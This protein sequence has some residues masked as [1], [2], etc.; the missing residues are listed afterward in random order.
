MGGLTAQFELPTDPS[1]IA[2]ARRAVSNIL[3][4]WGFTDPDWLQTAGLLV[5][6]LVSNAI[7]HG[8]GCLAVDLSLHEGAVTVGAADGNSVVPYPR[9]AEG[10]GGRGLLIIECMSAGWGVHDHEGGK[11]VWVQLVPHPTSA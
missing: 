10:E 6:E 5:S 3:M 2:A 11:R 8:G 7:R 4:T 1:A 9:P